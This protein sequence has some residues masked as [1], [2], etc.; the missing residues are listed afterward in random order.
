MPDIQRGTGIASA[1]RSIERDFA[2]FFCWIGQLR[3]LLPCSKQ[4]RLHACVGSL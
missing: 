1:I 2:R 4:K 3:R